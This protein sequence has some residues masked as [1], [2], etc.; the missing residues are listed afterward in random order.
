MTLREARRERRTVTVVTIPSGG[1]PVRIEPL[2]DGSKIYRIWNRLMYGDTIKVITHIRHN[3]LYE[4]TKVYQVFQN[5]IAGALMTYNSVGWTPATVKADFKAQKR[6]WWLRGAAA[7]KAEYDLWLKK[8]RK[9]GIQRKLVTPFRNHQR[10]RLKALA[11]T[12]SRYYRAVQKAQT[13]S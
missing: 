13:K 9:S 11:Q 12:W 5:R 6:I 10:A 7:M 4:S 8:K 2:G 1:D 3:D